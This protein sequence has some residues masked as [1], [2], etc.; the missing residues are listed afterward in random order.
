[1]KTLGIIG[2]GAA[3]MFASLHAKD[4][5]LNVLL[6]ERNE[7]I[8]KKLLTTGNGRC[9]YTNMSLTGDDYNQPEIVSTILEQF[10]VESTLTYFESLGIVP[11]VLENN[12]VFPM[13]LQASSFLDVFLYEIEHREI[14]L[15]T[16]TLITKIEQTNNGFV[17]HT[18]NHE[19]YSC[20]YVLFT[21]GGK[22]M[23]KS[24][25]DGTA[26]DLVKP[27][28]HKVMPLLPSL[29][30]LTSDHPYL[31]HLDGLKVD[32]SV[33]LL[34]DGKVSRTEHGDFLFAKYGV[35]GPTVLQLSKFALKA[36]EEKKQVE[37][38]IDL[39]EEMTE[40]DII[41]RFY[42]FSEKSISDSL[43]GLIHKRLIVPLLK[44]SHIDNLHQVVSLLG[45]QE[46]VNIAQ[47]IKHYSVQ[48]TGSLDFDD[49]QATSGGLSFDNINKE[50]LESNTTPGLFFAG[51]VLDID[52]R[53]GGFNLQW[54][55]SSA[56]VGVLSMKG[57]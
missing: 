50:T 23:P 11:K 46:I 7:R 27:F 16:N 55:W 43:I 15:H 38:E 30:K 19:K 33:K 32:T 54:A 14:E 3:G 56:Y 1:M 9:N 48:I 53:S 40:E 2:A 34:I 37:L 17:L 47:K 51:E 21:P 49:A 29:V 35:S 28:G 36:L 39:A 6:F 31:K 22:A 25:S 5:G 13:S 4:K 8:G 41:N 10:S 52:G 57:E 42:V 44:E 12:K 20:D 24:G 45:Y 26:Y 18:N